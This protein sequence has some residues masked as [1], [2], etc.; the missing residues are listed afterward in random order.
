LCLDASPRSACARHQWLGRLRQLPTVGLN[1]VFPPISSSIIPLLIAE[2]AYLS[3][4][5]RRTAATTAV[6]AK[7]R[8]LGLRHE[9]QASVHQLLRDKV[10]G[11]ILEVF[12]TEE[13]SRIDL[14]PTS[15]ECLILRRFT[16]AVRTLMRTTVDTFISYTDHHPRPQ[17]AIRR[18]TRYEPRA[19]TRSTCLSRRGAAHDACAL[20]S[21]TGQGGGDDRGTR[22]ALPADRQPARL[23]LLDD[24]DGPMNS[25]SSPTRSPRRS[26]VSRRWPWPAVIRVALTRRRS[27]P[28]RSF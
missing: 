13:T 4:R 7:A 11:E 16:R 15:A 21:S 8:E 3:R 26:R 28:I 5:L 25:A 27:S 1:D 14:Q 22:A 20:T 9:Q 12:V 19:A 6:L 2:I 23:G 17:R 18:S 10:L 24:L